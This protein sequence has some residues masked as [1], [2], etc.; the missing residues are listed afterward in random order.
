MVIFFC[1]FSIPQLVVF[2]NFP[3]KKAHPMMRLS[4]YYI[5]SDFPVISSGCSFPNKA[6]KV[7]AISAKHPPSLK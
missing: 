7:G 2:C 3:Q 4:I 6:I 1:F 5:K